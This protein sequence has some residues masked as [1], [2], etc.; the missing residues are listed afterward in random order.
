MNRWSQGNRRLLKH[1]RRR[2]L[3]HSLGRSG[4]SYSSGKKKADTGFRFAVMGMENQEQVSA[5][6]P[7]KYREQ[8]SAGLPMERASVS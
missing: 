7:K 8:V 3:Q 4:D 5:G 2:L 6:P 1:S